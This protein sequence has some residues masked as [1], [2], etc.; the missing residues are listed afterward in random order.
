MATLI[1][2]LFGARN[3]EVY[4]RMFEAGE[5]CPPELE[6]AARATGALDA[7]PAPSKAASG[8]GKAAQ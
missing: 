5:E 2:A 8:K 6:D 4:P 3:G 7:E 1:K